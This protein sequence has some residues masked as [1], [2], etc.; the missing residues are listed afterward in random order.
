MTSSFGTELRFLYDAESITKGVIPP[1]DRSV[2][3]MRI[4]L[5]Q[6]SIQVTA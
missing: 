1:K 3:A 5:W 2:I 4:Q 6:V